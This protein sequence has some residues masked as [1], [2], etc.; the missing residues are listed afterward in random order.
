MASGGWGLGKADLVAVVSKYVD[1]DGMLLRFL[2]IERNLCQISTFCQL[3]VSRNQPLSC[4]E[5]K[6]DNRVL[7]YCPKSGLMP[8]TLLVDARSDGTV[9]PM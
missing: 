6:R 7:P 5:R 3:F 2:V 9:A 8:Q 4:L 1:Y